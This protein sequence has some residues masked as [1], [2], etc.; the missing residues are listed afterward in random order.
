VVV[1]NFRTTTQH[2][3][4]K[5]KNQTQSIKTYNLDVVISVGYRVKSKRGTQ[6]RKWALNILK[7]HLIQG[8][9]INEKRLIE[10]KIELEVKASSDIMNK[11]FLL[12]GIK[13][14]KE[15]QQIIQNVSLYLGNTLDKETVVLK[16]QILIER[17]MIQFL[18]R[19]SKNEQALNNARFSFRHLMTMSQLH[20]EHQEKAWLWELLEKLCKIRND[21][22]HTLEVELVEVSIKDF[23]RVCALRLA[24]EGVSINKENKD[25][26]TVLVYLCGAVSSAV[27]EREK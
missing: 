10:R 12:K 15:N 27:Q 21:F 2:G 1:R 4:I 7:E 8:Y 3:A 16:A 6:F 9:S 22:A 26:K 13:N 18:K 19:Q 25:L 23:I 24:G 14:S 20:H 17:F 11:I 5:D